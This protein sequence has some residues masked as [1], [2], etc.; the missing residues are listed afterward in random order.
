MDYI[1]MG[2]AGNLEIERG[3]GGGGHIGEMSM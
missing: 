3:V 1:Y 2:Q